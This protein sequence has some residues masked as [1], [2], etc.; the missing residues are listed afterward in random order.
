MH[1]VADGDPQPLPARRGTERVREPAAALVA[2]DGQAERFPAEPPD[3]KVPPASAGIPAASASQR[4]TWFSAATAPAASSQEIP[5]NDAADT[6]M[7]NSSAAFVGAAGMNAKN[8]GLSAES[9][10]WARWSSYSLMTVAGSVP[11]AVTSPA[12]RASSSAALPG[13]SSGASGIASRRV[14]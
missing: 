4:S 3:T 2:G 14:T 8:R 1:L 10:A 12:S 13:W 11:P 7:S 5:C 9:T 6:T